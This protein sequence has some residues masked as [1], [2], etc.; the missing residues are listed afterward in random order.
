VG[1]DSFTASLKTQEAEVVQVDW[2][3]SAGGNADLAALL[4]KMKG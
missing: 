2:K 3:P 1:L 4:E